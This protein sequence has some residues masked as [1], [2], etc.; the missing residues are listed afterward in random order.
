MDYDFYPRMI[1]AKR[2]YMVGLE[3]L[4]NGAVSF[5]KDHSRFLDRLFCIAS[6]FVVVWIPNG[7]LGVRDAHL[8]GCISPQVLIRE[9]EN[10]FALCKGPFQYSFGIAASANDSTMPTAKRFE[11]G[12]AVNISDW[13]D[14]GGID[15]VTELFPSGFD[16]PNTRHICHRTARRHVGQNN[17]HA[18]AVSRL[19]LF[20]AICQDVCGFRHEMDSAKDDGSAVNAIRSQLAQLVGIANQVCVLDH[21]VLLVVMAENKQAFAQLAFCQLDSFAERFVAEF[22]VWGER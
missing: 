10:A 6:K 9:K 1:L 5:P 16:L 14:V 8:E 20:R 15:H 13:S 19:Q 22:S 21:F 2:R 11:A 3:H 7:H 12:S 4:M 17:R 18:L